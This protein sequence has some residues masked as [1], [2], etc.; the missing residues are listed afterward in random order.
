MR[1]ERVGSIQTDFFEIVGVSVVLTGAAADTRAVADIWA[2][3]QEGATA[4][5]RAACA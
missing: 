4:T 5:T 3:A 2:A 1:G